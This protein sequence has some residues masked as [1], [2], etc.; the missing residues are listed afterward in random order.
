M[1]DYAEKVHQMHLEKKATATAEKKDKAADSKVKEEKRKATQ[2]IKNLIR[3][4]LA[5]KL[6]SEETANADMIDM[7][8]ASRMAD[9]CLEHVQTMYHS[10][11]NH[12]G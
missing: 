10:R 3:G 5:R 2:K 4:Y 7:N 6:V 8:M 11:G 9:S 1:R 12:L